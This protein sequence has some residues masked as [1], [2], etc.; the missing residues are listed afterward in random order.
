VPHIDVRHCGKSDQTKNDDR[1]KDQDHEDVQ[2]TFAERDTH[3]WRSF[4][5]PLREL[6]AILSAHS[7]KCLDDKMNVMNKMGNPF[8][9]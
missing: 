3:V 8:F 1:Y 7:K 2:L 5:A 4:L 9:S 6:C